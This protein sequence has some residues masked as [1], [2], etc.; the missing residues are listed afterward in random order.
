M[1]RL[2]QNDL[3]GLPSHVSIEELFA[4]LRE[5]E[6]ISPG[7]YI[8][9]FPLAVRFLRAELERALRETHQQKLAKQGAP[10]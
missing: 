4:H 8:L 3:R 1:I 2:Y 7:S 5:M 6:D 9:S 10:Q